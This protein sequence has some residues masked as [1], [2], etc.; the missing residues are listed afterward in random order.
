MIFGAAAGFVGTFALQ[1][2]SAPT[3]LPHE[4]LPLPEQRNLYLLRT[5]SLFAAVAGV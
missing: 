4:T 2:L 3:K 1:G 5:H